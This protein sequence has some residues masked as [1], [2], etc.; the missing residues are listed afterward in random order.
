VPPLPKRR[1]AKA[2]QGDRRSHLALIPPHL[3][4]CPQCHEM[5]RPH[6]VCPSCGTYKGE[7]VLKPRATK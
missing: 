7:Q 3:V 1:T 6:Q 2:R 5:R 4:E